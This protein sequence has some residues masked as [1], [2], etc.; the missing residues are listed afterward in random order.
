MD[1]NATLRMIQEALESG[2]YTEA[3]YLKHELLNWLSRGGFEPKWKYPRATKFVRSR[4]GREKERARRNAYQAE[5]K[6]QDNPPKTRIYSRTIEIIA[7]KAGMPH[8]CDAACRR[9]G[10]RYRHVFKDKNSSIFGLENG[11][12]LIGS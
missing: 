11:K 4:S 10:H 6:A 1:P 7:S 2:D 12:I 5:S 9:A 8:K 3:R